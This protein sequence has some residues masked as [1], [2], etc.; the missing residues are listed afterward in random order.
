MEKIKLN[1]KETRNLTRI[2]IDDVKQ[3]IKDA[4]FVLDEFYYDKQIAYMP[5]VRPSAMIN[6]IKD[7]Y[8]LI[9]TIEFMLDKYE[10]GEWEK[11]NELDRNENR[12]LYDVISGLRQA[13]HNSAGNAIYNSQFKDKYMNWWNAYFINN[14]EALV[15]RDAEEKLKNKIKEDAGWVP[16]YSNGYVFYSY[17][18]DYKGQMV[19]LDEIERDDGKEILNAKIVQ[20]KID[21]AY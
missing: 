15:F 3:L 17:W 19:S 10:K 14:K 8:T 11:E 4:Q 2:K 18:I 7:V 20:E 13:L 12:E 6:P 16:T 21:K 9:K 1:A 5:G